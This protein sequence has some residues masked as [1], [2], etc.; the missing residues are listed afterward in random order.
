M[1]KVEGSAVR[2]CWSREKPRTH[3]FRRSGASS[4]GWLLL[5]DDPEAE[6]RFAVAGGAGHDAGRAERGQVL[7]VGE[8]VADRASRLE[9]DVP[10]HHRALGVGQRLLEVLR[11]TEV[12]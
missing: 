3:A 4:T 5:R 10:D 1:R 12:A 9:V 8:P 7:V 6:L 11:R 2:E